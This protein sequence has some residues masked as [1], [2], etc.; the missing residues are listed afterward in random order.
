MSFVK[1]NLKNKKILIT[2]AA[3]LLGAEH[4]KALLECN[5]K[6]ILTDID[7][8]KL[9]MLKKELEKTFE[10]NLI[11][12]FEM[13]VTSEDSIKNVSKKLN[14]AD[15]N[16]DVLI[17]NAAIDPKVNKNKKLI[18]TSRL[19]EFSLDD[20]NSQIA[21]GL[22]G[23]FLCSKVFGHQ[24]AVR[25][26]GG[27]IVNIA[28]DLSIIAPDQRIYSLKNTSS[29]Q[30]PVKPITYSVIKSGIIGLTKYLSTYWLGSNIRCNALSPGGVYQNQSEEFVDQITK[31][32]PLSRMANKNE[33]RGAIQF[34]CSDA[35]SYMNGHN[36]V[37]DGGRSVW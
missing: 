22:T 17:N 11:Y 6:L 4:A 35:S 1:F 29:N 9:N 10:S 31:L 3:G 5:A 2:G 37:I 15:L 34:L 27:C 23:A 26:S 36:L 19:E 13:D 30:Q 28:S 12:T 33:Y 20:W 8:R 16:I 7:K 14:I 21:V 18:N 32:I 25:N 24:M